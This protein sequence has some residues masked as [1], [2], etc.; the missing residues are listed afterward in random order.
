[1][2]AVCVKNV[3]IQKKISRSTIHLTAPQR[4]W[5]T[6][7]IDLI[8]GQPIRRDECNSLLP[9]PQPMT[10]PLKILK[11][12]LLV[13]I[14]TPE[15]LRPGSLCGHRAAKCQKEYEISLQTEFRKKY[16]NCF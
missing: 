12:M 8:D 6:P 9:K 2:P 13:N 14:H 5:R 15:R 7:F 4:Y 1:M 3:Q 16:L 11:T 10:R